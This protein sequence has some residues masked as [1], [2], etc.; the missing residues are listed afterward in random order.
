M[1]LKSGEG[2]ESLGALAFP[3]FRK[4]RGPWCSMAIGGMQFHQ[5]SQCRW[6]FFSFL[7]S[8]VYQGSELSEGTS[9]RTATC[10]RAVRVL[11]NEA[12]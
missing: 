11:N 8:R 1:V 12:L 9:Y 2:E 10:R 7:I 5:H 6:L 3:H 4:T